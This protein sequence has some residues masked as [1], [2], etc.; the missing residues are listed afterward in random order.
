MSIKAIQFD[1]GG[2]FR[3]FTKFLTEHGIQHKLICHHTHHQNGVV[4]SKRRHV[5][6]LGLTFLSQAKLPFHYWDHA[7]VSSIYLINRLPSYAI[8]NEVPYQKLFNKQ[9]DYSFMKVFGCSCFPW[10]RPY[11]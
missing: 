9:P 6:E 8:N 10:L 7:F 1:W 2:E 4:E 11:N 5:V 3:P